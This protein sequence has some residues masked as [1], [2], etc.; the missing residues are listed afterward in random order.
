[1]KTNQHEIADKLF[2]L[3]GEIVELKDRVRTGYHD[4]DDAIKDEIDKVLV[5][6]DDVIAE[7][8]YADYCDNPYSDVDPCEVAKAE[9]E[10]KWMM[11]Q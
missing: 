4:R 7:C 2:N 9:A 11:A 5:A 8:N 3:F 1:M 6:L 10:R